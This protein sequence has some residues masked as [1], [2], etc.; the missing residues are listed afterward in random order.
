MQHVL[1]RHFLTGGTE[2]CDDPDDFLRYSH[3]RCQNLPGLFRLPL[4][5]LSDDFLQHLFLAFEVIVVS[6][7]G[8]TGFLNDFIHA[9]I[10]IS[11]RKEHPV[12]DLQQF[13]LPF[14]TFFHPDFS[15]LD[16]RSVFIIITSVFAVKYFSTASR[17]KS[18]EALFSATDT[19]FRYAFYLFSS[20]AAV[21]IW[22]SGAC[23]MFQHKAAPSNP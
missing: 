17:K 6:S 9:G 14:L 23:I 11:P 1:D 10:L 18:A 4:N 5:H 20:P 21:S 19:V 3:I 15:L 7:L 16:H 22:A 13:L 12:S 2:G 8:N